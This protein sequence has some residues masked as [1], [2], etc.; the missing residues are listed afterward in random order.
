MRADL[1]LPPAHLQWRSILDRSALC[2]LPDSAWPLCALCQTR[3]RSCLHCKLFISFLVLNIYAYFN[4]CH[5]TELFWAFTHIFISLAKFASCAPC[6]FGPNHLSNFVAK[7]IS[8]WNST[9]LA[10]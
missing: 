1:A 3:A 8:Y 2:M 7:H 4:K 6:L 5:P 10:D 9:L